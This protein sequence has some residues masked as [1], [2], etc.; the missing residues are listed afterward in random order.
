M[1]KKYK[2][3]LYIYMYST[4]RQDCAT[5]VRQLGELINDTT[6]AE[7]DIVTFLIFGIELKFSVFIKDYDG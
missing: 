2:A 6:E 1:K 3:K 5:Y 4:S 7:L